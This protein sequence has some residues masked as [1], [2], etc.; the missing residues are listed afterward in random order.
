MRYLLGSVTLAAGFDRE[1]SHP[2]VTIRL[3]ANIFHREVAKALIP[4]L[5]LGYVVPSIMMFTPTT[6]TK[7]WQDWTAL[8][9]F[10]PVFFTGFTFIFSS[11]LVWW[12]RIS[13]G[14][15]ESPFE[16]YEDADVPIL[17]SVYHYAFA[18]QTTAHL[19]MIAYAYFHPAITFADLFWNLPNPFESDWSLPTVGSQIT[20]FLKYDLAM[21]TI[22][23]TAHILYSIWALRQ[24]GYIESSQA[25]AVA[26]ASVL[27]HLL[28][29]PG[30][31]WAGV[32]SWR[33]SVFANLSTINRP[34]S[35]S[36]TEP[37]QVTNRKV[38]T[39]KLAVGWKPSAHPSI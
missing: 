15:K 38:P 34:P 12:K 31:T 7:S 27:G 9:Q 30:A 17:K 13:T 29:G 11:V 37:S 28:V 20:V 16:M 26:L 21:T 39:G 5:T 1:Q 35:A 23:I 4:A 6:N 8:W 36:E 18:L 3:I 10:S 33:E 14:L 22:A 25:V 2:R 32:W 19:A 24:M